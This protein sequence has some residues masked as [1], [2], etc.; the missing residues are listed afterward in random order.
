VITDTVVAEVT[1]DGTIITY[2][3]TDF[4]IEECGVFLD[5]WGP[6]DDRNFFIATRVTTIIPLKENLS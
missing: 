6:M 4:D 3:P 1:R 5:L 2:D